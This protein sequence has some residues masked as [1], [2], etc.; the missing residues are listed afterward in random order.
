MPVISVGDMSQQFISMRNSGTIK[1][2]LARLSESLSSGLVS[3]VARSLNGDTTRLTGIN[4]SL[5]QLDGYAQTAEETRQTLANV[6]DVLGR[7][8]TARADMGA[9]FLLINGESTINQI[10]SA[11]RDGTRVFSVMVTTLNTQIADRALL[12]GAE[13]NG[14]P[15]VS[16]EAMLADLTTAIGGATDF[17]TIDAIITTWFD[18]PAGGFATTA[19]LGDTGAPVEKRLSETKTIPIEARADDPAIRETLKSVAYA[20]LADTLPGV[21]RETKIA[22]LERAGA[23][24]FATSA[25]LVSL[26]ARVGTIEAE[27]E[28]SLTETNTQISAL[29]SARND[30][31]LAD[32]FETA[33]RLQSVQ[34]QLETHYSV[35]ARLS[36]LSLLRFI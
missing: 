36:E 26:Q 21:N 4:Y 24:M 7:F 34:I 11:A 2:E 12:G 13:V 31:V 30:F 33:S 9:Q 8:D 23:G 1:T 15:L 19:Y 17:A 29:Q 22:M 25:D 10:D 3:D 32:P 5:Q 6:Q 16:S 20:A 27:V 28:Q 18:D 35:T 14:P